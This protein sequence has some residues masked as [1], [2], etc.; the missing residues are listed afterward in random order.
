[1]ARG[2]KDYDKKV[3]EVNK[4]QKSKSK[5]EAIHKM[6]ESFITED[7]EAADVNCHGYLEAKMRDMLLSSNGDDD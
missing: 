4:G 5:I 3:R 2:S 6:L 1:M 7:T